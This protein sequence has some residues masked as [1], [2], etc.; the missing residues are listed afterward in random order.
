MWTGGMTFADSIMI[1]LVG[2][3]VVFSALAVLAI[4][5]II[6]SKVI[7]TLFKESAP[8]A[9]AAVAAPAP[10][11]DEE[12]YACLLFTSPSSRT[13][14][15]VPGSILSAISCIFGSSFVPSEE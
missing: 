6:I 11:I 1:S 3:L 14:M 10:A 8:K 13:S 4:A 12:S 15:M 9:A 5:V 7:G 2:L